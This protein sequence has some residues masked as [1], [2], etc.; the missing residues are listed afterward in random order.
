MEKYKKVFIN[1]IMNIVPNNI[2]EAESTSL[3]SGI[4][5]LDTALGEI[6]KSCQVSPS[7]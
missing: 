6:I 2:T 5:N 7:L 1:T 3:A 4:A